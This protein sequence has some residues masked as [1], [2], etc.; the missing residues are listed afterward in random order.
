MFTPIA[1]LGIV[2]PPPE[3]SLSI[4]VGFFYLRRRREDI[5]RC[6]ARLLF[7]SPGNVLTSRLLKLK[8]RKDNGQHGSFFTFYC[9]DNFLTII[10]LVPS[11]HLP[12]IRAIKMCFRS[13]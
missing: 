8:T 7:S 3:L 9:P 11:L 5:E 10:G 13:V 4:I 2:V 1:L 12:L 6:T